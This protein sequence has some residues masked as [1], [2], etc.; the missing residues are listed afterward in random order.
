[1]RRCAYGKVA[2]AHDLEAAPAVERDG[3]VVVRVYAEQQAFAAKFTGDG[4]SPIHQGAAHASPLKAVK[5]IDAFQLIVV[6][7]NQIRRKI[8]FAGKDV[9]DGR[10]ARLRL[11]KTGAHAFAKILFISRG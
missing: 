11:S 8:G 6:R 4:H 1:M 10:A 5:D 3:S 2:F 9:P 7:L